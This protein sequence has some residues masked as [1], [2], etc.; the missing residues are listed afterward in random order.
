[1]A[2]YIPDSE[3]WESEKTNIF[4]LCHL[5]LSSHILG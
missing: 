1:M 3:R 5:V 4:K 2:A